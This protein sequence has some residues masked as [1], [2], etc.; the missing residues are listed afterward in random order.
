MAQEFGKKSWFSASDIPFA[1]DE[2][3]RFLPWI[4]AFMVCLTG[5]ML[6]TSLSLGTVM[7]RLSGNYLNSFTIQIPASSAESLKKGSIVR[8]IR[9]ND[10]AADAYEISREEMQ[11]LIAPWLG[12]D[13]G[14]ENLPLPQL[15]EVKIRDGATVDLPA[16]ERRIRKLAPEAE[17]DDYQQWMGKF[18]R[19]SS[20][21][22]YTVFILAAMIILTTLAIVVLAAKTALRLHQQTVE[23]LYTIGAQ[24][25]Y[26]AA[27]F[28]QN[29]MWLVFRGAAAGTVLAA[30][31]F[32]ASQSLTTALD[33]PLLPVFDF[34]PAHGLLFM[35]LPVLTASAALFSTRF[36]VLAL[37]K[38][39]P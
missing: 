12:D 28:Q 33:S 18:S 5:L 11:E 31:L 23:V 6:A 35:V 25:D 29:A 24:D 26:I 27:Q 7:Q 21:V 22:Q 36:A 14:V 9:D 1:R 19:F 34:T 37:L 3:N 32:W 10:W 20:G 15:I 13:S 17:I 2:A 16:L 8:L 38:R 30:L 4:V 39:K